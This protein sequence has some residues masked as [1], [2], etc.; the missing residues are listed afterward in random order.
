METEIEFW[1]METDL[2]YWLM[3]TEIEFWLME[4]EIELLLTETEVKFRGD[5]QNH[6]DQGRGGLG[7]ERQRLGHTTT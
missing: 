1:L 4:A 7:G 5:G 2:E 6:G 3:E